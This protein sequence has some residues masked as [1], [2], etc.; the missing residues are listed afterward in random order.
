[1]TASGPLANERGIGMVA[2]ALWLTAICSLT[3]VAV[4]VS[5]I[6]M[7]AS[8]VQ[9]A[10]DVAALTGARALLD[11]RTPTTDS[12]AF[13]GA[14]TIDSQAASAVATTSLLTGT[15]DGNGTF[16]AGTG[17]SANAVKATSVATVQNLFTG[18]FGE[19]NAH[20]TLT[21]TATAVITTTDEARPALPIALSGDC[22]ANFNCT[23][24]NCPA[25]NTQSNN[26]GWTGL[27]SGHSK[28]AAEQ[29]IPAPCG[30]GTTAPVLNVGDTLNSTN[31]S[32]ASLF[33]DMKCLV[34][35]H[36]NSGPF[37]LPV[38]NKS[39]T[40]GFN[41]D[42]TIKGFA[43]VVVDKAAYCA[44]GH[45]DKAVPLR[46][47]RHLSTPGGVGGCTQCGTGFVRLIG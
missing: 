18:V 36:G 14:N 44:A 3:A 15:V 9:N 41:G 24:G 46:S 40:G 23:A 35:D 2:M 21:K 28:P 13:L 4:D 26:A 29:Y 1:M 22:F 5:R 37:L 47:V 7:T 6:A 39:C 10:A 12:T 31:G 19:A 8:E 43:T 45:D 30:G 25:L 11:G 38:V 32:V 34:C 33:H 20:S 42:F 16:T 27:A 17:P